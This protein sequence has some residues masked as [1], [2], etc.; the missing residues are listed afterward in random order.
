MRQT[1]IAGLFSGL[2]LAPSIGGT[3]QAAAEEGGFSAPHSW[4]MTR[5]KVCFT[6]HSHYGYGNGQ[7]KHAALRVAI[8]EWASFTRW[9]YGRA[10]ASYGRA[11]GKIV[12]YTKAAKGWSASIE[13]RPCRHKPRGLRRARRK[14]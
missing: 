9:E 11:A 12:G 14:S 6:T 5:N 1:L 13:A 8:K 3:D 2:V 4:Y 7:T 10:W